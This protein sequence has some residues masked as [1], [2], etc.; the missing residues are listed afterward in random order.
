MEELVALLKQAREEK[1]ISLEEIS[2]LTRIQLRYLQALENNNFSLFA[3]EV[4]LKGAITSYAAAAGL[5][6][7]DILALYHRLTS[8]AGATSS[9]P[10]MTQIAPDAARIKKSTQKKKPRYR[11]SQGP[12]FNAGVLALVL[13]LIGAGI[14]LS[15]NYTWPGLD[16]GTEQQ[17]NDEPGDNGAAGDGEPEPK[18]GPEPT[19]APEVAVVSTSPTETIYQVAGITVIE[20]KLDFEAPCWIKLVVDGSEP[21]SPRTFAAGEDFTITATETIYLRLG[22]PPAVQLTVNGLELKE[23]RDMSTPHNFRISLE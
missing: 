23:N 21:F 22:N 18:P 13:I 8:E 2:R 17:N 9:P 14:W 11:E 19:P 6:T 7:K 3:G 1:K 10:V 16:P 12:P 20:L 5:E 4:Y 15:L